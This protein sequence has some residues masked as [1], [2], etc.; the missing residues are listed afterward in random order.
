MAAKPLQL[1]N[2]RPTEVE[3]NVTSAGADDAGKLVALGS[4][5]RLDDTVMPTGIG[6][7][8]KVIVASEALTAGDY[9]NIHNNAGTANVRKADASAASAGKQAHGFVLDNVLISAEAI[10]YFEGA[11]TAL[12][13]LTPGVTYVLSNV[14]PGGVLA[15]SSAPT[16][17]GH[18][19]QTLG[20]A[21]GATE[22]NVEI[23][24]SPVIR[25]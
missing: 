9:V 23:N 11:N 8:A 19:L 1:V 12:T 4:D 18:L 7:D 13:G 17:A 6:K 24:D 15:L 25:G 5:G 22:I 14:T 16:T 10:V 2:N 3:A 21:T 20:I